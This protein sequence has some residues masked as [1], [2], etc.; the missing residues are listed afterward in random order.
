MVRGSTPVLSRHRDNNRYPSTSPLNI[1]TLL[2]TR[3][4]IIYWPASSAVSNSVYLAVQSSVHRPQILPQ[5]P[6]APHYLR[7][8]TII[9]KQFSPIFYLFPLSSCRYLYLLVYF[10]NCYVCNFVFSWKA[11]RRWYEYN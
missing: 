9:L 8:L 7:I 4:R 3:V 11:A 5:S 2:R 6:R 1:Q 10:V